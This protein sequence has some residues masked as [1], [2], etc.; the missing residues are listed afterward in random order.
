MWSAAQFERS[1]YHLVSNCLLC[2]KQ[3]PFNEHAE[4]GTGST[5]PFHQQLLTRP[6]CGTN[7]LTATIPEQRNR[8]SKH[9][10]STA[11]ISEKRMDGAP[12]SQFCETVLSTPGRVFSSSVRRQLIIEQRD[13]LRLRHKHGRWLCRQGCRRAGHPVNGPLLFNVQG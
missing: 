12:D 4:H 2:L 13:D 10:T 3:L 1:Q 7:T 9:P 8:A 5:Q 6:L 11:R